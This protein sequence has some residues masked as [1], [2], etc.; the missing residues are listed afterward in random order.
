MWPLVKILAIV[1]GCGPTVSASEC[2]RNPGT[3]ATSQDETSL[4]QLKL[5][6]ERQAPAGN[7]S[8]LESGQNKV[9]AAH[10]SNLVAKA[11]AAQANLNTLKARYYSLMKSFHMEAK[12]FDATDAGRAAKKAMEAAKYEAQMWQKAVDAEKDALGHSLEEEADYDAKDNA[13]HKAQTTAEIATELREAAESN[14][15]QVRNEAQAEV[16]RV[17][18]ADAAKKAHA[19]KVQAAAAVAAAKVADEAAKKSAQ[20]AKEQQQAAGA[21]YSTAARDEMHAANHAG[22]AQEQAMRAAQS[23]VDALL[24]PNASSS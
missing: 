17:A 19:L 10:S 12:D 11:A 4:I 23:T 16:D 7:T 21:A 22:N 18:A 9:K 20:N 2:S 1:A 3:C 24:T 13:L 15:T 6:V 5:E 14:A 8:A